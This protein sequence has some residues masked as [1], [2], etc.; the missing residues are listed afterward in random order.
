[1]VVDPW[2]RIISAGGTEEEIIYAEIDLEQLQKVRGELPLLQH[3][4]P[5]LYRKISRKECG[6]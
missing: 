3:R 1:M 6:S 4:R 5:E 2:G